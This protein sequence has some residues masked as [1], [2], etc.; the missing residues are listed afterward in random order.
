ME[1]RNIAIIA[2]VDHGKT[3]LVDALLKQTLKLGHGEELAERAMDSND[4][5]RERGITI[6]AKNT[7]VEYG[8]V[9][10]NI[11]DTPGH[12]DFGGEVERVLGMVSGCLV[13]V[14]AA[15][16][17]MPQTRFVLRKA[18]E[19]GLKPIVVIN[20]IDRIDAR[21]EEVVNLTFD[22]M[23]ELGAND[24]QLDFPI[25]YA[26]AREG[27]AFRD[28][29][30]PQDDMHELFEMVLEHIPAPP[31]DLEAPF[32]M[33]VTNLDYS[34]YLG[35]IVLGRVQRGTVKKGEFVQLMHKD[36]TMTKSRVIQPFTH[37]GLRRIE[38]DEV[39]AGD[40]VALAGIEDA[41]IGE[42]VAD[43][44]DPEALPIITVDEPT[45][46]MTFQPNTSP[47]A[48]KDG[49][50]VTSRHLNDRLKREVMTNVSLKVDEV[51]PDEFI[52]SGRGELHLSIL[53]ETMRREGYEVQVGSPQ[54]IIRE[55]DGVKHEPVEH[56]VIDVPEQHASS[57]IGVLGGRKGQM[58]NM[59][60]QG[61]RSRVEFKI[62]SRALFGF[63]NQFLSMTQGEGI[64]S[65]VFDG[66]A[67]WAGDIKIRQNGSLVSMED[68]PA[69][70]YSIWK[71][72]D[73]GSFFIDAGAEV[74]VGMIV[75]E[76]AREQDMNVNVCKNKK[77]T[78]VRSSGADDALTLTPPRRLSLEDALE[79]I[80][81][82]ELVE[83]TPHNIR[84]RKK[85]LNPSMR[86]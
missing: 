32:Q 67:P 25:L 51:R 75:G 42:T 72:Q 36:G 68:G 11:V 61:T 21:P 23:A 59:E 24:D 8:G 73:R 58:V 3:T 44:A 70:A 31:A 30:K 12:A 66:Y 53:L 46:S 50:Y 74:Y 54:V 37:M 83:L 47:F 4:L 18:I 22:L 81:S 60:P 78:N 84:L 86:K 79:Y 29:D 7:A 57:V 80:G 13:L 26:I 35:R 28:L 5:E 85:V 76:N 43:L 2:H 1:Y 16:G 19:L 65:H 39:S 77:L 34:E 33:L 27:K 64:M 62:P 55:I 52:V 69:F 56:L 15:E 20:K 45:V 9:K 71:L 41:Q 49:K 82:D 14:D 6:L 48:G 63:R 17:P 10:I 38:A 40:I